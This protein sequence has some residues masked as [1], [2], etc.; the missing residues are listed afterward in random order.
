MLAVCLG[1][2]VSAAEPATRVPFIVGLASVR[3][4]STP[5]GDY[6]SVREVTFLD[7]SGYRIKI[8]GEVP[9]DAGE[10]PRP[11]TVTR[12]VLAADQAASR[13][14]RIYFHTDDPDSFRGTAPGFSA[15]VV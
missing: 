14:M 8:S 7:A 15:A 12:K 5:E 13:R 2:A 6:E 10:K 9:G 1:G 3:A 4:V 11:V